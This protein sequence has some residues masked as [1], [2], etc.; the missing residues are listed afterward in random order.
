[1]RFMKMN[2]IIFSALLLA[3]LSACQKKEIQYETFDVT[4]RDLSK[5]VEANGSIETEN[6]VEVYAPVAGRM[7]RILVKEGDLIRPKQKIAVMSSDTRSVIVDMAMGKS[8]EEMDYWKNQLKET[9]IFA[10]VGG[11]LIL[12]KAGVGEKIAGSIAQISTG[13]VIRANLDEA[14]LPSVTLGQNVEIHFDIHS[15]SKIVGKLEKISQTSKLV[16]NLNVYQVEVSLPSEDKQKKIPFDIKIGMSV[17][18]YF[19][20]QEKKDALSL[21]L[22]AVDGK[23]NATVNVVKLDGQKTKVKLGDA[24]GDWV[25]VASGLNEGDKIKVPAFKAQKG[26]TRKSP[27]MMKKD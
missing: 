27:L 13:E 25:E 19:R 16:N 4:K 11:K 8:K 17:T 2:K 24:Y 10:P 15:K 3:G 20:V 22:N 14:D 21:P 9:P 12:M 6:T 18:L 23:S 5:R 1:M 7:D 26:K